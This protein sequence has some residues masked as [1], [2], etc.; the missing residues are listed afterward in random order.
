MRRRNTL[1]FRQYAAIFS[2]KKR[3]S[4]RT[5]KTLALPGL[6]CV[7]VLLLTACGGTSTSSSSTPTASGTSGTGSQPAPVSNDKQIF[8]YPMLDSDIATFDP[9]LSQDTA[10]DFAIKAVFTGLVSFNNQIQVQDQLGTHQVSSDGLTYTFTINPNAKFSDGKPV[11]PDDVAF[12][13]DRTMRPATKSPVAG[14]MSL[15]KDFD[16]L[17]TGKVNTLIGDSILPSGTNTVKLII[18]KPAAYFLST[19]TYDCWY[20]VEKSLVTRYGDKWTEHLS[21]GGGA[22]PYKVQQWNHN[23]GIDLIPNPYWYGPKPRIQHIQYYQSGNIDT[24]FKAY[25]ANQFDFTNIPAANVPAARSQPDFHEFPTLVTTYLTMNYLAKPFDIIK[26]R[27]A[28]ALAINRDV[29]NNT[30]LKNTVQP[31]WSFVPPGMPGHSAITGP[32]GVSATAGDTTKAKT[33]FDEGLKEGGYA[34]A[35]ALPPI[36]MTYYA[37]SAAVTNYMNAIVNMWKTTLGVTI[38][39]QTLD[40]PKLVDS[41]TATQNNA[42]GLQGWR[43]SWQADYPDPQDWLSIFFAPKGDDNDM[44]YGQNNT[45][46]AAQQQQVQQAL[47]AADVNQ[48]NASRI[49]AYE[50]AEQ[51]IINDVGVIPLWHPKAQVAIKTNV[52]GIVNNGLQIIP[53]NDWGNIYIAQS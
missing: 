29:I 9:A 12:S 24:T 26:I 13:I 45:T 46:A 8:R 4:M 35:A 16:K 52:I 17:T 37:A 6:L 34:N 38:T 19:M 28:F 49:K 27:Q 41:I 51:S 18:S 50:Q 22:G 32:D 23:K 20:T 21:E 48:D 33:L 14:Y 47:A 31:T 1:S 25:Q 40:F 7:L 10:S 11:T 5:R 44:N 30:L 39:Q 15:L 43:A 36:K 2:V 3:G 42:N 53:P